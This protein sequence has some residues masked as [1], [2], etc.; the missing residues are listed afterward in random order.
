MWNAHRLHSAAI[1]FRCAA[2]SAAHWLQ[3]RIGFSCALLS[4]AHW[5]QLARSTKLSDGL[6]RGALSAR[7]SWGT[8]SCR[9]GA[10]CLELCQMCG[11]LRLCLE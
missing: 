10:C 5:V 8:G 2:A 1:G 11:G 6:E 9:T 3:L 7:S 4:A